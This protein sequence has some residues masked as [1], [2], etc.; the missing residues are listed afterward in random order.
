[1][2]N[3]FYLLL[4]GIF[5][6]SSCESAPENQFIVKG[7]LDNGNGKY[8]SLSKA[9][10]DGSMTTIDSITISET[11]EFELKGTS[12]N[13]K[14]FLLKS[15]PNDM[16]TLLLDSG[17]VINITGDYDKLNESASIE[18]SEDSKFVRELNIQI[19][20]TMTEIN[21]LGEIYNANKDNPSIDSIKAELDKQFISIIEAQREYS[22]AFIESHSESFAALVALSQQF[23]PQSP[24]FNVGEDMEYFELVSKAL[25]AQY[26]NSDDVKGL[27]DFLERVKNPQAEAAPVGAIPVGTEAPEINLPSPDGEMISLSSLRG[28]YVLLDFWAGWCRPCRAESPN[29]VE[30]FKR[31][32]S[33]GFDIYQVSLD[34]TK[35]MWVNA[36]EKDKVGKWKHV[37][38]LKY[39]QSDA[40]ALYNI[41]SIPANFLLDPEGKVIASNL[42]GAA[43]GAKL[44]EIYGY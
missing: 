22:I 27:N 4:A 40:A 23:A 32:K 7:K 28:N 44:K 20:K 36:I 33:K 17:S 38:D 12:S 37:S 18:G 41:R 21:A 15:S 26:P 5:F 39:W 25:T 42:R 1:M 2:R 3:I 35:E 29:L 11:G 13:P 8:I 6:L 30:N 14:F 24:V 31:Y 16:I 10:N 9:E 43:L 19:Q 34:E